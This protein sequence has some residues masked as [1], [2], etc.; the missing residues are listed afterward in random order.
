MI[1]SIKKN[2]DQKE[3]EALIRTLENKGVKAVEIQGSEY[4]V[5]GLKERDYDW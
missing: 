5:F 1:I 2:A 3:V 4:N